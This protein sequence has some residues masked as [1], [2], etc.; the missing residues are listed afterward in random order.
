MRSPSHVLRGPAPGR[1]GATRSSLRFASLRASLAGVLA[2][3]LCAT[4]LARADD[5]PLLVKVAAFRAALMERHLTR[6]GFVAYEVP[7]STIAE[8]LER[9]TYPPQSD[10]PVHSGLWAATA[11]HEARLAPDPSRALQ[12]ADRAL[13]G[14]EV[15]MRVTGVQGLLARSV[16][17]DAGR[18]TSGLR[19]TWFP[20]SPGYESYVWRGDV[21]VDQYASGLL[22]AAA[23]CAGLFPERV[24][25]LVT[26]FASHLE[27]HEMRLVDADGRRTRFGDLSRWS[28]LGFNSIFQL[29]GYAAFAL[30]A[31]LSD[32]PRFARR[33][34]ELRDRE[35]VVARGRTTNL[36]ILGITNHSNDLMAFNLYRVLIPLARR[37]R[38]PALAD[39][40]H[41]L[42]RSWLRVR[43]DQNAYFATLF[44]VLEPAACDPTELERAREFLGR[45]PL[46]KRRLGPSPAYLQIPRRW[47][48]GRKL[49]PLARQVVPIELRSPSTLEWKSSPYRLDFSSAPDLESTGIDFMVAYWMLRE[50]EE[51]Q[52][53][54]GRALPAAN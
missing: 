9:G 8:D 33:R 20:G 13:G 21:S 41:G 18:D 27:A 44:C 12:D 31:E 50:A 26:D 19:G 23:E 52:K 24:A 5:D 6:E 43:E 46:E 16:R 28:G 38:D 30:A 49:A 48:P 47:I 25:R 1:P 29:T 54:H 36:R 42:W 51:L 14:L 39:L 7:L 4:D 15:L 45:F 3:A 34:D 10:T 32:E 11:C 17:R 2:L 22:P 40:R 35:R 53:Q 37:T